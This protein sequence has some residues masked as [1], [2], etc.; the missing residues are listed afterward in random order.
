MAKQVLILH[1]SDR[2]AIRLELRKLSPKDGDGGNFTYLDGKQASLE[3]IRN[4]VLSAPFDL[5][6]MLNP[7][8]SAGRAVVITDP[9][10][11]LSGA[12]SQ[13]QFRAI[14]GQVP[15]SIRLILVIDDY[16]ERK[17]WRHLSAKHWLRRWVEESGGRGQILTFTQPSLREM[18]DW[19]IKK[20]VEMGGSFHPRAAH[21]LAGMV[22][23]ET[24]QAVQEI[25][26]L[27]T[28]VNRKRQV[29]QDDVQMLTPAGSQTSIFDL[30]DAVAQ[31]NARQAQVIYQH[32]LETEDAAALFPM[33][34]RQFRLLLMTREILN[35]GKGQQALLT[36]VT[37]SSYVAGKLME[38]AKRFSLARL[39]QIYHSLFEVEENA[40]TG[41]MP[42]E[43]ALEI[44]IVELGT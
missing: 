24:E 34:V 3:D 42:L 8:A 32:L 28:Y 4:A 41:Q 1:G 16:T 11:K 37:N 13:E 33:V 20:A 27:L 14:L 19:I 22:G 43:L 7:Q 35:E 2:Y 39:E 31:G 30:V 44:L 6:A 23:S 12:K 25:E 15:E 36:D 5:F 18:P 10:A 9:L 21:E 40:K 26:K 29:E 17:D 38:Q